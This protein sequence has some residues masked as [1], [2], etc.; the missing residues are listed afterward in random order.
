M[1]AF[2]FCLWRG[3][4]IV[5]SLVLAIFWIVDG[6]KYGF[7]TTNISKLVEQLFFIAIFIAA[8]P[9]GRPLAVTLSLGFSMRKMMNDNNFVRHLQACET[10]GGATT[11]C[12]DK[13]G[14]LTQNRMTVVKFYMDGL[15]VQ[16]SEAVQGH[17]IDAIAINSNAYSHYNDEKQ[18][19]F[20][21]VRI[22]A[23]AAALECTL[24]RDQA[25]IC[26]PRVLQRPQEDVDRCGSRWAVSRVRQGRAGLRASRG[27]SLSQLGGRG[28]R[29]H[30]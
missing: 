19:F 4:G 3:G 24:C 25:E 10:M 8:V 30:A 16:L 22:A 1:W 2:T 23:D 7:K 26:E 17:L 15:E 9:E 11:I 18:R 20:I 27:N 12:S 28:A 21:R 14:T 13:T 6:A 5:T 29:A